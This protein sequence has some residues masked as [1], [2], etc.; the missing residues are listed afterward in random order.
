MNSTK[1]RLAGLAFVA[2][3]AAVLY[4]F[5]PATIAMAFGA[6]AC[7]AGLLMVSGKLPK[8]PNR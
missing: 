3:G 7:T 2:V 1:D 6:S 8:K 5:A 4:F